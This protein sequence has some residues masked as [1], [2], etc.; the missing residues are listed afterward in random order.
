MSATSYSGGDAG[1]AGSLAGKFC[2][3]FSRSF[4]VIDCLLSMT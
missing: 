3:L 2:N 4:V 1:T